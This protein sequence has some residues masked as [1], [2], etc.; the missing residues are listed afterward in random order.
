MAKLR[1]LRS[2]YGTSLNSYYQSNVVFMNG[3]LVGGIHDLVN[4]AIQNFGLEDADSANTVL[5]N[6]SVREE[7]FNLMN[8]LKRPIVYL[9]LADRSQVKV[10]EVLRLGRLTIEL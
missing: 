4:L 3:N 7:T 8:A 9:S 1:E 6:R 2:S 10:S 5:F